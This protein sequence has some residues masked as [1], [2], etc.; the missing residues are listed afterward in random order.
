ME[1]L[2]EAVENIELMMFIIL[3]VGVPTVFWTLFNVI[4]EESAK[5][6]YARLEERKKQKEYDEWLT[7]H[8]EKYGSGKHPYQNK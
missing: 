5:A 2:V 8:E 1:N 4:V 6:F 3:V 7:H